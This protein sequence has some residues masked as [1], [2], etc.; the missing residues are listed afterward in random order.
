MG[1][2]DNFPYTNFHEMNLDWVIGEFKKLENYVKNYTAVNNVS[3]AGIW[4]I[5]KQYPQWAIVS[6]GDRTYMSNK[7]VPAGVAITNVEYWLELADLDPRIGGIIEEISQLKTEVI[8]VKSYGA[9]G[10]G[11][12]DDTIP[13]RNAI[14]DNPGKT[15]FFPAGVYLISRTILIPDYTTIIGGGADSVIK[16]AN[17]FNGDMLQSYNYT[18]DSG[19]DNH[20]CEIHRIALSNIAIDGNRTGAISGSGISIYCGGISL[21]T[22][23]IYDQPENG[24][25][26]EYNS[27]TTWSNKLGAEGYFHNVRIKNCGKTGWDFKGPHD[28]IISDCIVGGNG[29]LQ[30]NTYDNMTIGRFGNAKI[31]NCHFYCDYGEVKPRYSLN[32]TKDASPVNVSNCHIEGAYTPL[33]VSASLSIFDNCFIYASFGSFDAI[34]TVPN[35]SFNNCVFQAGATDPVPTGRPQFISALSLTPECSHINVDGTF[36]GCKVVANENGFTHSVFRIRGSNDGVA[37]DFTGANPANDT[38]IIDVRGYFGSQ[39]MYSFKSMLSG[40]T[41]TFSGRYSAFGDI[42]MHGDVNTYNERTFV[43]EYSNGKLFLPIVE[44]G[45]V[46][47]VH[48]NTEVNVP[49]DGQGGRKIN[50]A[51]TVYVKPHSTATFLAISGYWRSP[52]VSNSP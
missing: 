7:P 44:D 51:E 19:T 33:N 43:S 26:T 37:M 31:S 34:V 41:G 49:V 6:D 50:F 24:L 2:F 8:S 27:Y 4:D 52:E 11:L 14:N 22:V 16:R 48:N 23:W 17:G 30:N 5:R 1:F 42:A 20:E 9:A 12:K 21:D 46:V 10:D 47:Y 32:I 38:C 29:Q 45:N 25:N 35:I 28:S 13:V 15:V 36:A 18:T 39:S 40:C 3:Y